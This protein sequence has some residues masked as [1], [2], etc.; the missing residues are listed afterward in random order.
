MQIFSGKIR[1]SGDINTE[2]VR[3]DITAAEVMVLRE[4]HGQDAVVS[5]EMKSSDKR[6]HAYEYERLVRKYSRSDDGRK[7]LSSLFGS[8]QNP[9]LPTSL[10]GFKETASA[11]VTAKAEGGE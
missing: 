11:K 1:P 3:K 5:L 10:K 8:P 2:I 7:A 6:D 4:I 9:Q